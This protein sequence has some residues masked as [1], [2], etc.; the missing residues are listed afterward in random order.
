MA[1]HRFKI[2]GKDF[3][4][5]VGTR[6]GSQVGVTVNGKS[7]A[8]EV[9]SQTGT[10][11]PQAAAAAPPPPIAASAAAPASGGADEVRAPIS[12]VVL[13]VSVK[14]GDKVE[15]QTQVLVL[16][17]MKMENEIFAAINGTVTQVHVQGQ[18]EVREGDLL[19][20]I[21]PA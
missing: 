19:V 18:Q 8:V 20:S 12:G 9:E 10:I 14:P 1:T 17:A 2:E 15:P 21:K 13:S 11:A 4:V 16:E 3:E 5:K 7:Y 6:T